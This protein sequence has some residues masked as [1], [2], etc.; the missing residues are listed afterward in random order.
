MRKI[1]KV[2]NIALIFTLLLGG[3]LAYPLDI[4]CL[5]VP[6]DNIRV[7]EALKIRFRTWIALRSMTN[8][9]I[10]YG[11]PG[12]LIMF[13]LIVLSRIFE[14]KKDAGFKNISNRFQDEL[15]VIISLVNEPSKNINAQVEWGKVVEWQNRLADSL[16]KIR[17]IIVAFNEWETKINKLGKKDKTVRELISQANPYISDVNGYNKKIV[18][19]LKDRI[20]FINDKV[21]KRKINLNKILGKLKSIYSRRKL[22]D[23]TAEELPV[24]LA[25]S[26]MIEG[27]ISN[28]LW[29][30]IHIKEIKSI[31]INAKLSSG[32]DKVVIK[33]SDDGLGFPKDGL[34]RLKGKKYQEAFEF[35]YSDTPGG[36]RFVLAESRVYIEK[37]N[38]ILRVDSRKDKGTTFTITLP[39]NGH[40]SNRT[41]HSFRGLTDRFLKR[42]HQVWISL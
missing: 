1:Y 20:D 13:N 12:N 22:I 15:E 37:H 28:I 34:V 2:I 21:E 3:G 24:I 33:I 36:T 25:N 17:E 29:N 42:V 6:V 38:G 39:V 27:A 30:N 14:G 35:G 18:D 5:R 8:D 40:V 10:V 31:K 19:I 32:A 7:Q 26:R 11:I 16:K 4:S 9:G 41:E 23:F